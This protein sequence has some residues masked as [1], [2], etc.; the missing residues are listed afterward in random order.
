MIKLAAYMLSAF[1]AGIAGIIETGW[2]G[3]GPP[4][5]AP[6][7]T[8]GH[9]LLPSSGAQTWWAAWEAFGALIGSA[10]LEVIRN[11]LCLLGV[12]AFWQGA[13]IGAFIIIAVTFDRIR[14]FRQAK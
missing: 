6:E 9:S 11:S 2:L 12:S 10:L 1:S 13:F 3:A 14:N 7:W 5:S 4:I 8:A